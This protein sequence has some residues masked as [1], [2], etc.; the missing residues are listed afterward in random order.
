MERITKHVI[1][2]L[3]EELAHRTDQLPLPLQHVVLPASLIVRKSSF[4]QALLVSE[5]PAKR[6]LMYIALSVKC[7]G[8]VNGTLSTLSGYAQTPDEGA[9]SGVAKAA[10]L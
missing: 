4:K 8:F 3:P 5:N 6:K 1:D 10:A 7:R 9:T 2:I